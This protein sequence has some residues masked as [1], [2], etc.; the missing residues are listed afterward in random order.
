MNYFYSLVIS[1]LGG[2]F[3]LFPDR[4]S[5]QNAGNRK[6]IEI[7]GNRDRYTSSVFDHSYAKVR[8]QLYLPPEVLCLPAG[9]KIHSIA[10][11]YRTS[12]NESTTVEYQGK[13][14]VALGNVEAAPDSYTYLED[15]LVTCYN[16][17]DLLKVDSNNGK[18]VTYNFS[19]PYEYAGNYLVVDLLT[20]SSATVDGYFYI[21]NTFHE[22]E[23]IINL[24]GRGDR[25]PIR[26]FTTIPDLILA[27][28]LPAGQAV[29][30]IPYPE[31]KQIF[32]YAEVD[33]SSATL[34][35]PI[36]NYGDRPFEVTGLGNSRNFALVSPQMVAA[37]S[38]G[39]IQLQ[40]TPKEV[41]TQE[42][43][44]DLQTSAGNI[45]M[46]L[47]GTTYRQ[48]PY[49]RVITVT[50]DN[51]LWSQ[52][53]Q[54][55]ELPSITELSI[56]G[57]ITKNDIG[58]ACHEIPNLTK[59][60]MSAAV[61]SDSCFS[62]NEENWPNFEQL[63]LPFGIKEIQISTNATNLTKLTL[64]LG[65]ESLSGYN[66]ETGDRYLPS[67]LTTLIAFDNNPISVKEE[68]IQ[69]IET[70]YVPENA[71]DSW[72]NNYY[73]RNKN[74]QPITEVVLQPDFGSS[75][76]IRYDR[77]FAADNYPK[78]E[79]G[80]SIKPDETQVTASASLTNQAPVQI[81]ELSM[82]YKLKG[83]ATDY[84]ED[85]ADGLFSEKGA[86]SVFINENENATLQSVSFQLKLQP[87][88][89]HFISFPFDVDRNAFVSAPENGS[90]EYVIRTYDGQLR[91]NQGMYWN[92]NWKDA[93]EKLYAGCGYIMQ[94]EYPEQSQ[95]KESYYNLSFQIDNAE[96]VEKLLQTEV[97]S[98]P[99]QYYYSNKEDDK[100]WNLIGN[101]YP[102]FFNIKDIDFGNASIIVIWDGQG[103]IPLSIRDDS[104]SLRPLEAFFVQKPDNQEYITFRPEGRTS[105][106]EA[107]TFSLLRSASNT[108]RKVLNLTLGNEGYTD[109][110]R[111]VINPSARSGFDMNNDAIKWM[112]S[113][114][115]IPQ[116]YTLG[117]DGKQ[118]AINERPLG[119]GN[120]PVGFYVGKSGYYTFKLSSGED[121]EQVC[122]ID[123]YENKQ[124]DLCNS[125]YSFRADE[126][127]VNDRF[128]IRLSESPTSNL[129]VSETVN[130]VR[131]EGNTLC[132]QV[133][134]KADITVYSASGI[135]K[136]RAHVEAGSTTVRLESGFY[137][138][139][140][141]ETT[142]K[143]IIY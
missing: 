15:G 137:L 118:Y 94:T 124:V 69:Y 78:G 33:G 116:F 91:A 121:W 117:D 30:N 95:T 112:S 70:V 28:E 84:N 27:V 110:A 123:K 18:N 26:S 90:R 24:L 50:P 73:W 56:E 106:T 47:S 113:N 130:N 103:Y 55:E 62:I 82:S 59:L 57:Q 119:S 11:Q 16:G 9:T 40:F 87:D 104:Y 29:P 61:S 102:S 85:P 100:S 140:I 81:K 64:P 68:T 77:T 135:Q 48:A 93:G 52:L 36:F 143:V 75:I 46:K 35:I 38:E 23:R 58:F 105:N 99:L 6:E 76:L 122:L 96:Q 5:A 41:G 109:R 31:R 86:Y 19:E 13:M 71:I 51:P 89:W 54:S 7:A 12:K 3:F 127:T 120:I 32:G 25:N 53:Y 131:V 101:P 8:N 80:I 132:I 108:D 83:R 136:Y 44:V 60:D 20:V 2:L 138:V 21:R 39:V 14:R 139:R 128:E 63:A 79:I 141:N 42:E 114:K 126:G 134:E 107:T 92:A 98:I 65:F 125:D 43:S 34:N 4:L 111:V 66:K 37:N 72:K 133:G 129:P 142:H 17:E 74:I 67:N 22:S 97:V 88:K 49:S 10:L 45:A 1:L 115:E